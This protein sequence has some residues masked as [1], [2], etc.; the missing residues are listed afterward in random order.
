[1]KIADYRLVK[2]LQ[3]IYKY[4]TGAKVLTQPCRDIRDL[5]IE[6]K[7]PEERPVFAGPEWP[8]EIEDESREI[9]LP[10]SLETAFAACVEWARNRNDPQRLKRVFHLGESEYGELFVVIEYADGHMVIAADDCERHIYVAN[11]YYEFVSEKQKGMRVCGGGKVH[12]DPEKKEIHFWDRS[13]SFGQFCGF[14]VERL[15]KKAMQE[16]GLEDYKLIIRDGGVGS[17]PHWR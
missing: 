9:E 6:R 15:A 3:R 12:A 10:E 16:E 2:N 8:D 1:M 17:L 5:L 11:R 13:G 4:S 14:C 7:D